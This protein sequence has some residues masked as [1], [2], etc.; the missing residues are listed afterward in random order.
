MEEDQLIVLRK[1]EVLQSPMASEYVAKVNEILKT[2]MKNTVAVIT[3]TKDKIQ[4]IAD[5][6]IKENRL[7]GA[8]FEELMEKTI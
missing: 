6:L 7:T 2:E 5:V 4:N 1:E 8:Q 3:Q